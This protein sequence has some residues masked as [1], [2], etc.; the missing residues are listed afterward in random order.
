MHLCK[1]SN[2]S[3]KCFQIMITIIF[4]YPIWNFR[5]FI[6][7]SHTILYVSTRMHFLV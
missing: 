7:N 3:L 2:V 1:L 4:Y 6:F 5:V